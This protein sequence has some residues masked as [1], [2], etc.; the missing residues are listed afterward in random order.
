MH[1]NISK[2]NPTSLIVSFCGAGYSPIAPGTAGSFATL[3]F[4]YLLSFIF[5]NFQLLA[6]DGITWQLSLI[7]LLLALFF[8]IIGTSA[9]SA[10]L[11]ATLK[12]DP[13]EVVIDEVVGQLISIA[14]CLPY[15]YEFLV[16]ISTPDSFWVL[17]ALFLHVPFFV[18]RL[19][20]IAKPSIIGWAD[21]EVEGAWGVMLDDIFAGIFAGIVCLAIFYGMG[22]YV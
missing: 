10:Y 22:L 13:K 6:A 7:F 20:D 4:A 18:F 16:K 8:T 15:M 5:M 2:L 14:M 21:R 9:T 19:F 17:Y 12:Q 3:I 1:K 11:K